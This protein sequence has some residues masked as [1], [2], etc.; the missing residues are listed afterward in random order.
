MTHTLARF[1]IDATLYSEL[2]AIDREDDF[3]PLGNVP[4]SWATSRMPCVHT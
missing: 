3:V 4:A 1:L 2:S